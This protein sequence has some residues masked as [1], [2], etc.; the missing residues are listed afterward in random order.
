MFITDK[1]RYYIENFY[2][3]T[4]TY[5]Y[6]NKKPK[7]REIHS[8]NMTIIHCIEKYKNSYVMKAQNRYYMKNRLMIFF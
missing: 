8:E 5:Y 7:R 1:D 6:K 4:F 2:L 3:D